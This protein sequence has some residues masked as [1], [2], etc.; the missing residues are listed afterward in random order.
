[1]VNEAGDQR[2]GGPRQR[3]ELAT[4]F[5][6]AARNPVVS[7]GLDGRISGWNP[8]AERLLG[9]SWLESVG[10]PLSIVVPPL[11]WPE[12]CD[13]LCRPARHRGI[14]VHDTAWLSRQGEEVALSLFFAPIRRPGGRLAGTAVALRA[15]GGDALGQP[16]PERLIARLARDFDTTPVLTALVRS[17]GAFVAG[18]DPFTDLLGMT[19]AQLLETSL[20][21]V[22]YPADL[23]EE[24]GFLSQVLSGRVPGY[25]LHK[26]FVNGA[27]QPVWVSL[28]GTAVGPAFAKPAWLLLQME[29]IDGRKRAEER[30]RHLAMHDPLTDLPN[31]TVLM[32]RLA[33]ALARSARSEHLVAVVFID[34][35]GFKE[36][37]DHHGHELGDQ[38]LIRIANQ[39]REITR[40]QDT[41]ARLGGDEFVMVCEEATDARAVLAIGER[42]RQAIARPDQLPGN[43]P[44]TA[45]VGISLGLGGRSTPDALLAA[46]DAAMYRAKFAGGD[47]IEVQDGFRHVLSG[48]P[49]WAAGDEELE[50]AIRNHELRLV[51]QPQVRLQ[52]ESLTGVEALLR[53]DHPQ[54]GE[55]TPAQFLPG[56]EAG[57]CIVSV[58]RW[59]LDAVC[60]QRARWG[61]LGDAGAMSVNVSAR[62]LEQ[63]GFAAGVAATLDAH[64][65]APGALCLELDERVASL[66]VRTLPTVLADLS[67]LGIHLAVDRFGSGASSVK[68]LAELPVTEVKI[69]PSLVEGIGAGGDHSAV[70]R[71]LIHVAGDM[72]LGAVAEG[73]ETPRQAA[74]LRRAG[75]PLGQGFLFSRPMAAEAIEDRYAALISQ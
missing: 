36:V 22:T 56:A 30:L 9:Y 68:L 17:D 3:A 66:A 24:R 35:D 34:L 53:W 72:G 45:S 33:Q 59:V 57:D 38:L 74:E 2:A 44:A 70:G 50:R 23:R 21:D 55:L 20:A 43:L 37:N 58:G 65:L 14:A 42:I 51:Y 5:G 32:D 49:G 41:V 46:A 52:G 29:D 6:V 62:E 64:R 13:V 12:D 39:L 27:G 63:E 16:G 40:P 60:R 28:S 19:R 54:R 26:R 75:C 7:V 61:W 69:D 15:T 8:G 1:M 4:A 18:N 71:A 67:R 48:V 73:V 25:D 31:R 47:R 10:R 11:R